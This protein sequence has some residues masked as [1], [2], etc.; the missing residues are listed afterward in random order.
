M[1]RGA[2]TD[3]EMARLHKLRAEGRGWSEIGAALGRSLHACS[4][5]YVRSGQNATETPSEDVFDEKQRLRGCDGHLEDLRRSGGGWS[6]LAIPPRRPL[7]LRAGD[8]WI[9]RAP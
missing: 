5:A 9:A 8:P 7:P 3:A 2:W 6:D 1:N 4:A